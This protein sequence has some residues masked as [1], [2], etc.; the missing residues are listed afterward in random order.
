MGGKQESLTR[1]QYESVNKPESGGLR[2]FLKSGLLAD[3]VSYTCVAYGYY[4][5]TTF[6][7]DYARSQLGLPLNEFLFWLRP[8]V[9]VRLSGS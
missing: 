8:M 4:G 7:V 6:L 9:W 3:R 2:G 5:L 1:P